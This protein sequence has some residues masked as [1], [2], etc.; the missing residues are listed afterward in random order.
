MLSAYGDWKIDIT[1]P[2][3]FITLR[4]ISVGFCY[5]DGDLDFKK[6][7]EE[8]S[9]REKYHRIV[10]TPSLLEFMAYSLTSAGALIGPYFEYR[11][12]I[13]CMYGRNHYQDIPS[14]ALISLRLFGESMIWGVMFAFLDNRFPIIYGISDEFYNKSYLYKL[15]YIFWSFLGR[16]AQFFLVFRQQEVACVSA[17]VGYNGVKDGKHQWDRVKCVDII[18]M[19]VY[20]LN[21]S[22]YSIMWNM[23]VC[24]FARNY[25]FK[26]QLVKGQR[27]TFLNNMSTWMFSGIWHGF[28][29]VNFELFLS[30]GM[31]IQ[32]EKYIIQMKALAAPFLNKYTHY[33]IFYLIS[34]LEM[35]YIMSAYF[36]YNH[37]HSTALRRAF[38]FIP[39]IILFGSVLILG[40][41]GLP[42]IIQKK[43]EP[44]KEEDL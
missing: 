37:E 4:L 34:R 28:Y 22:V 23:S 1:R 30:M 17:G 43:Y 19:E 2:S 15:Y 18:N 27:P 36:L 13:D 38:F 26:R 44:K 25:I 29:F 42:R 41:T 39:D 16:R 35:S 11:D 3:M 14:N 21:P 24:N 12:F 8:L 31:I 10:E 32:L 9:E 33:I 6:A 40:F 5:K 20:S 7:E